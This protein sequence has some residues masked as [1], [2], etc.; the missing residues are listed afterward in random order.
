METMLSGYLI[1]WAQSHAM[2]H[3]EVTLPR[4]EKFAD[5]TSRRA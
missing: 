5:E 1:R 3:H 2:I 4:I